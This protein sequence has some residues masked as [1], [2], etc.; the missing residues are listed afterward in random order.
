MK[1]SERLQSVTRIFLDTAPV[2][3]FVENNPR[4]LDTTRVVFDS[5]DNGVLAAVTSPVTLAECLILP[6]RLQ[7]PE[8]AQAFLELLVSAEGIRFVAIDDQIAS[9]AA[10]LRARYGLALPDSFQIAVAIHS[11]CDAFLT[12]DLAL[13]RVTEIS[14]IVLNEIDAE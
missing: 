8:V 7:Q 14:P 10:E 12:N 11:G 1:I 9:T 2:I 6:H 4:Y 3:Y 13:K 5:I